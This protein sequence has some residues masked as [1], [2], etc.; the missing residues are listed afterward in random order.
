MNF[1]SLTRLI[2]PLSNEEN[3]LKKKSYVSCS[4]FLFFDVN[5]LIEQTAYLDL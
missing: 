4:P 3:L 2:I 5:F 1:K